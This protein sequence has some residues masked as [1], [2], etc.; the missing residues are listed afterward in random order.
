MTQTIETKFHRLGMDDAMAQLQA[1][2]AASQEAL[3][4]T[5]ITEWQLLDKDG[6]PRREG[7]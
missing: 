1:V 4:A 7:N 3:E 5:P 2:K 6:K